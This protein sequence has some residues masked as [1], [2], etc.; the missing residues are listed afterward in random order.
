VVPEGVRDRIAHRWP[1]GSPETAYAVLVETRAW[2]ETPAGSG[3]V[4]STAMDVAIFGQMFLQNGRYGDARVLS[5]ASVAAM[6]RNQIPGVGHWF[7]D[8][9]LPEG[10]YGLGWDI[11]GT[12][13]ARRG[14]T[15]YSE[16]TF[17]HMGRGGTY[18][19]V[20]PVNEVVGVY[21]SLLRAG[22]PGWYPGWHADLFVNAV[23]AAIDR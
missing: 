19:W 5:P 11:H 9:Y 23:T 12:K 20:D 4:Y 3:G 8:E 17:E 14:A 21:F 1:P 22:A 16:Q 13:R 15:L 10:S 18:L 6:T 7:D 2:E